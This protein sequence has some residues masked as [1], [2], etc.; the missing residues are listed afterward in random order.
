MLNSPVLDF[1][2]K[3]WTNSEVKDWFNSIECGKTAEMCEFF[4]EMDGEL[5]EEF[6]SWRKSAP[7]F[8]LRISAEKFGLS[9]SDLVIFSRAVTKLSS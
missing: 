1:K 7:D 9:L 6:C 2:C 3:Q 8:F 5:L 4:E